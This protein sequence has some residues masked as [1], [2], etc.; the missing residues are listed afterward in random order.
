MEQE[1]L[2]VR[3]LFQKFGEKCGG[4]E[5]GQQSSGNG[6]LD[7]EKVHRGIGP[8]GVRDRLHSVSGEK[9][10]ASRPR[11][12]ARVTEKMLILE[13][14]ERGFVGWRSSAAVAV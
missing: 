10:E 9:E 14:G 1:R 6:E 12:L 4:S 7:P 5:P 3:K 13:A 2:L 11:L 8:A